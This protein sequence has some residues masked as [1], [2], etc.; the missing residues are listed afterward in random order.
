V[1]EE[2]LYRESQRIPWGRF[3]ALAATMVVLLLFTAARVSLIL[4]EEYDWLLWRLAIGLAV[5]YAP[6]LLPHAGSMRTEVYPGRV[7]VLRGLWPIARTIPLA[8]VQ[9]VRVVR[10]ALRRGLTGVSRQEAVF[11]GGDPDPAPEYGVPGGSARVTIH[12]ATSTA[13]VVLRLSSGGCVLIGSE[14]PEQLA[15]ALGAAGVPLEP[16]EAHPTWLPPSLGARP[17]VQR[18]RALRGRRVL[19]VTSTIYGEAVYERTPLNWPLV[20]VF[21][22]LGVAFSLIAR[23]ELTSE[24]VGIPWYAVP[25][26]AAFLA[27]TTWFLLAPAARVAVGTTGLA[28]CYGSGWTLWRVAELRRCSS[29]STADIV[30]GAADL[31][32]AVRERT[33][34][35]SQVMGRMIGDRCVAVALTDGSQMLVP[36]RDPGALCRA[37][38]SIGV[39]VVSTEELR[40]EDG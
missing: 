19:G 20:V 38:G 8:G 22:S 36:S 15:H 32:A 24:T 3:A 5:I 6:F 1:R 14:H 16:T 25:A 28:V 7:R 12:R 4:D 11:A 33:G 31:S 21:W 23:S 17:R 27:L 9:R 13:C 34:A 40:R 18:G 29:V 10:P 26:G 35:A 30:E 39:E 2:P 37:L